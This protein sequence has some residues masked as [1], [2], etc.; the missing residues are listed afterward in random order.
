MKMYY[1]TGL[2]Q[3]CVDEYNELEMFWKKLMHSKA[4]HY[5]QI[6]G[7]EIYRQ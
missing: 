2:L 3:K 7:E 1:Q 4:N 6:M 5:K